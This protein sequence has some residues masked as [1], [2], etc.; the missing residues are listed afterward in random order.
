[1]AEVRKY[2]SADGRDSSREYMA[3]LLEIQCTSPH[4]LLWTTDRLK[5]FWSRR[6]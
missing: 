6:G 1:M 5:L 2:M 3:K 4:E